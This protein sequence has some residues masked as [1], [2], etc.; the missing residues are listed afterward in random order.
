VTKSTLDSALE[1][2]EAMLTLLKEASDDISPQKVLSVLIARDELQALL[3]DKD[4]IKVTPGTLI[5]ICELDKQLRE[6]SNSITRKDI[7]D[8][9]NQWRVTLNPS[10]EAWW[11]FFESP[12]WQ[13][14][15]DWLCDIG[16][17]AWL[18]IN[19]SL[20]TDI[21]ARFWSAGASTGGTFAAVATSIVTLLGTGGS[22]TKPGQE[23]V[24]RILKGLQIPKNLW[25]EAKFSLATLLLLVIV[26]FHQSLPR[27]AVLYNN[28]G[29]NDYGSGNL[30]SAKDNYEL[31]IKLA[32]DYREAHYNLGNLYEDLQEFDKARTEYL[33]AAQG[34]LDAAYNNL[35]RLY[36]L[37][38]KYDAAI[39]WL[40]KGIDEA[41][42][43]TVKYTALKN[44]GWARLEQKRYAEAKSYLERAIELSSQKAPAHCLLAQVLDKQSNK[45][46]AISH[47]RT[48]LRWAKL[49]DSDEDPWIGLAQER[50]AEVEKQE[51]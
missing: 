23:A 45:K 44:L 1:F 48:C 9:L 8:E 13:D 3:N 17:I 7:F 49:S 20:M 10:K 50:L 18:T 40:L 21:A 41:K 37:N 22:L 51:K 25:Q 34:G 26:G 46:E 39:P 35:G 2:Y 29:E 6:Q 33:I 38:K 28:Q 27:I 19:L 12:H 11:W 24:E 14:R 31:A 15:F 5:K 4:N 30:S 47:W 42:D 43:N 36:I 32:P 16:T